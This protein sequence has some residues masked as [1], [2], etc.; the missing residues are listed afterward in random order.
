MQAIRSEAR[1]GPTGLA[2]SYMMQPNQKVPDTCFMQPRK[3]D[4]GFA[5]C[6]YRS[7]AQ[8]RFPS[9]PHQSSEPH[10]LTSIQSRQRMR[11]QS[12]DI[13][14]QNG[15]SILA[16]CLTLLAA[17]L[18]QTPAGFEP[19]TA[20]NLIVTFGSRPAFPAGGRFAL[21]GRNPL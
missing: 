5:K 20:G 3:P 9:Q 16:T 15:M 14:S 21:S 18:A 6:A 8:P 1:L 17:A 11:T 13:M 4:L 7:D 10:S 12:Q 2:A 19:S